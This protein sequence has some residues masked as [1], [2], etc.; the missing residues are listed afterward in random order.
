MIEVEESPLSTFC[1]NSL[2]IFEGI[3]QQRGG[4]RDVRIDL[5]IKGNVFIDHG[6]HVERGYVIECAQDLI[7]FGEVRA[8][9]F[10]QCFAVEQI[11]DPNTD[12]QGL[13]IVCWTDTPTGGT[14]RASLF[15]TSRIH[16]LM[17]RHDEVGLVR[18]V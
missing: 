4:V 2:A 3:V 17:V 5:R 18:D 8:D 1:E 11:Y 12:T 15:L 9:L 10:A 14:D 16:H 6:L 7:L 13:V